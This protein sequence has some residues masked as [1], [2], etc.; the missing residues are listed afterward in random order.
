MVLILMM[1]GV[2]ADLQV[3]VFSGKLGVQKTLKNVY[4][5]YSKKARELLYRKWKT[6]ALLVRWRLEAHA[7]CLICYQNVLKIT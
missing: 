5:V 1:E 7:R 6:E 3:S 4:I 2:I